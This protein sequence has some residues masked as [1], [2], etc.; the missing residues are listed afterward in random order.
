VIRY[1]ATAGVLLAVSVLLASCGLGGGEEAVPEGTITPSPGATVLGT[2][3]ATFSCTPVPEPQEFPRIRAFAAEIEAALASGDA[4]FFLS[5]AMEREIACTGQEQSG[6]CVGKEAGTT[7]KGLRRVVWQANWFELLSTDTFRQFLL[8]HFGSAE[9]PG[10]SLYALAYLEPGRFVAMTTTLPEG[11]EKP[12]EASLFVFAL[13][14]DSWGLEQLVSVEQPFI[15]DWL[16]A[17]ALAAAW[18][19][20]VYW[21]RWG[22]TET[23]SGQ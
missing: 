17:E 12:T 7:V 18:E 19:R 6:P 16:S 20:C 2:P 10:L 9:S 21:E 3:G 1:L 14:N 4:D 23:T 11:Q 8:E 13:A 5:R 22:V 15:D